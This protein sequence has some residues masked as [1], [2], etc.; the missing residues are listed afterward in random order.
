MRL[1]SVTLCLLM[2]VAVNQGHSQLVKSFGVKA[3]ITSA[4]QTFDWA[5]IPDP[6]TVRRVGFSFAAYVEW[7]SLPVFSVVTQ[8]E[9]NQR[10]VGEK[11]YVAR[12]GPSGLQPIET[13]IFYS[14]LDYL[15]VPIF[16]RAEFPLGSVRPYVGIGPRFDFLLGYQAGSKLLF[17]TFYDDFTKSVFGGSALAGIVVDNVLPFAV[18][19]EGRYNHD[20]TNSISNQVIRVKNNA[21]DV[22]LGVRL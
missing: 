17:S 3:G 2:I 20:F 13:Q 15:S 11:L 18:T 21:F 1:I 9:Y 4:D 12:F 6:S 10:G 22:W 19:I 5:S 7:L 8:L 14:R 16:A